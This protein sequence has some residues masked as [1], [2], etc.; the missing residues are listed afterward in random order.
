[1]EQI[2]YLRQLYGYSYGMFYRTS[3]IHKG[4]KLSRLL[5]TLWSIVVQAATNL[6]TGSNIYILDALDE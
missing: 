1:M 4:T 3:N 5:E 2:Y 6:E